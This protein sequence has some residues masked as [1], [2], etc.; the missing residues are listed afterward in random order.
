MSITQPQY[1]RV[2]QSHLRTDT[3]QRC[4]WRGLH[5]RDVTS[6]TQTHTHTLPDTLLLNLLGGGAVEE[7]E[8]NNKFLGKLPE[9]N[10][11]FNT[12]QEVW[13]KIVNAISV[14]FLTVA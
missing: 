8:R 9:Y 10:R 7:T 3:C 6:D 2:L 13:F 1:N 14:K 12:K 11:T 5:L 4:P